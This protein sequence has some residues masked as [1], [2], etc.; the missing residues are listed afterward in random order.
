M[1]L[2][3]LEGIKY[4]M[5]NKI[6]TSTIIGLPLFAILVLVG[7]S[8]FGNK[9]VQGPSSIKL[10]E[11]NIVSYQDMLK[12]DKS[13]FKVPEAFQPIKTTPTEK[14]T[15]TSYEVKP[16][17][18]KSTVEST[19]GD[20][21]YSLSMELHSNKK[22][23]SFNESGTGYEWKEI[24]DGVDFGQ[25][26]YD[27]YQDSYLLIKDVNAS[28]EFTFDLN[29]SENLTFEDYFGH[30]LVRD[31]E[32]N[33]AIY[34]IRYPQGIDDND[35]R[36]DY[37]LSYKDGQLRVYPNRNW[38]FSY[39]TYPIKVYLPTEKVDW[40][41]VLVKVGD[42]CPQGK[43]KCD[44]DGD[45]VN[46]RPA[47][48]Y[49]GTEELKNNALVKVDKLSDD[50]KQEYLTRTVGTDDLSGFS[51]EEK[52]GYLTSLSEQYKNAL[53]KIGDLARYGIE[54]TKL[55]DASTLKQIRDIDKKSPPIDAVG[56]DVIVKKNTPELSVIPQDVRSSVLDD[57]RTFLAK[58]IDS[59][60]NVVH[61]STD[62]KTIGSAG[63]RNYSS[64]Q[65]WDE[66]PN[67]DA[68]CTPSGSA[69]LHLTV[70]AG[71]RHN[72]TE[73]TGA[74]FDNDGN[75]GASYDVIG[76]NLQYTVIE[77]MRFTDFAGTDYGR[78]ISMGASDL[79][80][81]KV[82]IHDFP[83]GT[84]NVDGI[85]T[86]GGGGNVENTIIYNG[87][88]NG[89]LIASGD[90]LNVYNTVIYNLTGAGVNNQGTTTTKNVISMNTTSSNFSG[91]PTQSYNMSSD[92]TAS[93]TGCLSGR[94]A[95]NQFVSVSGGSED[96]HLKAGSEAINGGDTIA[97]FSD[98][99]DD[100]SRP[101]D[102]T[103]DMGA[104]E[105]AYPIHMETV[106]GNSGSDVGS[107][108]TTSNVSG[109]TNQLYVVA[110]SIKDYGGKTINVSGGGLS[111]TEQKAQC[112]G[113]DTTNA[114]VFT[115]LASPGSPFAVTA[116]ITGTEGLSVSVSRYSGVDTTTPIE[117]PVGHNTTS[118]DDTDC[119]SGTDDD[120]PQLTTGSTNANSV[121]FVA[122]GVRGKTYSSYDTDYTQRVYEH[123][124]YP[125]IQSGLYVHD[126]TKAATGDDTFTGTLSGTVDWATAGLVIRPETASGGPT[127]TNTNTNTNTA[128][129]TN[130]NTPTD[131][132]TNTPTNVPGTFTIE[133][134]MQF[135]GVGID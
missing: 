30:L 121:H 74:Y 109:G 23:A 80:I 21:K 3:T 14:P 75:L 117:D 68:D 12:I 60:F 125:T 26:L 73:A 19:Q 65:A 94:S 96:F 84:N 53:Y 82:I 32:T 105:Y 36:I 103:W 101:F 90:T 24:T 70:A 122:T 135:E 43:V 7:I 110:V 29:A 114:S 64:V 123:D 69:Y 44:K 59:V 71:E 13:I 95:S 27:G 28:R 22:P 8:L 107:S 124:T 118:E 134:D 88:R 77:W 35:F 57:N 39:A 108:A 111:W 113:R 9:P 119:S 76:D 1:G 98:D 72:G 133:G 31:R 34:I 5:K 97:D 42:N 83:D 132:P 115:A 15:A 46:I 116:S 81:S 11:N 40:D 18:V 129:N 130:T 104:D 45:I 131:T 79:I 91:S 92:G 2:S 25:Y 61:A 50:E 86:A 67:L 17:A 33:K 6:I 58:V 10:D 120:S 41:E 48:W 85:R 49:W 63:G 4:R 100:D 56:K 20:K 127:A 52:Q 128:T 126:R 47:G 55:A 37:Q 54:Y 89:I 106:S 78:A 62:V 51:E 93:G 38:Q 102:S 112:S 87:D 16:Q 66:V 99:I